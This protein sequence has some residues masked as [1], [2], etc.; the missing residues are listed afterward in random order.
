M[1]TNTAI[2][3]MFAFYSPI[4]GKMVS[5]I[6]LYVFA[7][8]RLERRSY[9]EFEQKLRELKAVPLMHSI[10]AAGTDMSAA[11]LKRTLRSALA[12]YDPILVLEVAADWASRRADHNL[13]EL[14]PPRGG[15][16]RTLWERRWRQR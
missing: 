3:V 5:V 2:L 10:W 13:G 1:G 14:I 8:Q 15:P 12:E 4:S 16:A 11:E 7:C 6:R 9:R